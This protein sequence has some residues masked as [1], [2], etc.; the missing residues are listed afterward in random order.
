[1]NAPLSNP[2]LSALETELEEFREKMG[3]TMPFPPPCF[4]SM[5]GEF[6]EY[7]SR[8]CLKVSFPVTAESL[9][10]Q[11]TMQG[12]FITAAFDNVF[13]PLSYLAARSPCTTVDIHTQF[14]RGIGEGETLIITARVVARGPHSIHMTAEAVN[15]AHKLIASSNTNL[16]VVQP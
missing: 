8:K 5:R 11:A 13:G 9:N 14:I 15:S 16:L 7:D 6:L 10:P 1:M 12:G 4:T 3:A 2:G